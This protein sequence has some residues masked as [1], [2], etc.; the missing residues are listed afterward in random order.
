MS[1]REQSLRNQ[2]SATNAAKQKICE[3]CGAKFDCYSA[4][5]PCWCEDVKLNSEA[6]A[7][8]RS[9]YNDCLCP[10]C[11]AATAEKTKA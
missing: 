6:L 5:G 10:N 4:S 9:Q 1:E 8:L 2:T 11:L 3:K 7:N